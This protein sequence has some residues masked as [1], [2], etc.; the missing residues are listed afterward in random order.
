MNQLDP[1]AARLWA[2]RF[3]QHLWSDTAEQLAPL[4]EQV[5]REVKSNS[6]ILEVFAAQSEGTP[7][8]TDETLVLALQKEFFPELAFQ[9]LMVDRYEEGVLH[10]LFRLRV[11]ANTA[12]DLLQELRLKFWRSRLRTFCTEQ[13]SFKGFLLTSAKN[14]WIQRARSQKPSV[15]LEKAPPLAEKFDSAPEAELQEEIQ[16]A[17]VSLA[18]RNPEQ[19]QVFR[20]HQAGQHPNQIAEQMGLTVSSVNNRLHRARAFLRSWLQRL[21]YGPP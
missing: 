15:S 3:D 21:G 9:T 2:E 11:D 12:Y 7:I 14:L 1:E 6:A 10:W 5:R 18:Q 4:I 16:C 19:A 20:L 13:A 17:L 8:L